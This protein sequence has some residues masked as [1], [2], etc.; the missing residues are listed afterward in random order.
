MRST[1]D[2]RQQ[3]R[4]DQRRTAL[5]A[6]LDQLLQDG[7][8][9]L[10][11]INIADISR[12]AGV[13]RSAFYFYFANKQAAVAALME[14]LYDDAYAV[15]RLLSGDGSPAANIE[16][17]I[18]GLFDAW[19]RQQHLFRAMLEARATS[20]A[21]REMWDADRESFVEPVAS[22]I[23]AERA[24]GR[25]PDGADANALASVLL[26]LNDRM[27]E[28][29]ALGGPLDRDQLLKAVVAIWLSTIYGRTDT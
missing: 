7:D 6:S 29:L 28:R 20:G 4:G 9:H 2:Q 5:L 14:Q 12:R 24:A 1:A 19:A 25:A 22:V 21:V 27:L 8:G 17:T 26:E 13:T 15:T 23:A 11:A 16:A 10:D 18:G 3:Q